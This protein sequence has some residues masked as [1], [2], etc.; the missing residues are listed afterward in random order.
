MLPAGDDNTVC[1]TNGYSTFLESET[2]GLGPVSMTLDMYG[3]DE[4]EVAAV[5]TCVDDLT[6]AIGDLNDA[7]TALQAGDTATGTKDILAAVKTVLKAAKD[8]RK[9]TYTVRMANHILP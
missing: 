2:H 4:P 7:V 1:A 5:G 8:C 6:E 9:S 3:A